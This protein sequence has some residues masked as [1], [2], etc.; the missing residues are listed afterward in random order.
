MD[1]DYSRNRLQP[2]SLYAPSFP[3]IVCVSDTY[4]F[5]IH[6]ETRREVSLSVYSMTHS[7]CTT[8]L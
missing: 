1:E 7:R 5:C 8:S 2:C 4:D 3:G 6:K